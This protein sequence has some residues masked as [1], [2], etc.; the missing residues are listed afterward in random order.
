VGRH[1]ATAQVLKGLIKLAAAGVKARERRANGVRTHARRAAAC[2]AA[3]RE[4]GGAP[5][6]GL[7]LEDWIK[8]AEAIAHS[9]PADPGPR[10]APVTRVFAFTIADSG[11]VINAAVTRSDDNPAAC[12]RPRP[13]GEPGRRQ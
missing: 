3:S 5:E 8:R 10:D 9:P 4:Q 12:A 11:Q 2:F 7:N 6:L 13:Q 1:G